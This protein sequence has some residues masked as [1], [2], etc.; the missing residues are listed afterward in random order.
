MKTLADGTSVNSRSYYFLLEWNE[1]NKWEFM[2]TNFNK[3]RLCDLTFDEY[4]TL[5][6]HAVEKDSNNK[7]QYE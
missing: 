2:F 3:R 1:V 6:L 4:Q 7:F 5:W